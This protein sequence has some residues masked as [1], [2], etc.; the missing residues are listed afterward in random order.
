LGEGAGHE[1]FPVVA[2]RYLGIELSPGF[3][4]K[5]LR[6]IRRRFDFHECFGHNPQLKMLG[7]N[8]EMVDAIA[9]IISIHTDASP[10]IY[11]ELERQAALLGFSPRMHAYFHQAFADW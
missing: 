6:Q 1:H 9:K 7:R 3:V 4:W 5:R 2:G 10:W 8:I 11:E